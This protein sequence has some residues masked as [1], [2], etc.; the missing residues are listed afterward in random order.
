MR[1]IA[2]AV[3][4]VAL[5]VHPFAAAA[6]EPLTRDA[7]TAALKTAAAGIPLGTRVKVR[8][9]EGRQLRATLLAVEDD[10]IVVVRAARVPEPAVAVP[11]ASLAALEREHRGGFSV[12]KAIGIGLA[13]GVGA[14]LTLFAIAVSIDD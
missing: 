13:A 1:S 3:I 6:Q 8:T 9:R 7:E 10:R 4:A 5:F 11:F 14:I 12:G 2:V